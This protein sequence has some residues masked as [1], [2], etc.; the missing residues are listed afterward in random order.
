MK[1]T[2]FRSYMIEAAHFLPC[3]PDGH[4]CKNIHGHN[5]KIELRFEGEIQPSGFLIDFFEIDAAFAPLFVNLD[6]QLLNEIKGLE[7]PTSEHLAAWVWRQLKPTLPMLSSV[8]VSE[9][10][11]SGCIYKGE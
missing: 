4:K 8:L 1:A 10:E 3:V 5:F 9:N 6:H 11:S 7:N 2:I